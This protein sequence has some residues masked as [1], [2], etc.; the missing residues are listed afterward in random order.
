MKTPPRADAKARNSAAMGLP[1]RGLLWIGFAAALLIVAGVAWLASRPTTMPA[2]GAGAASTGTSHM[3]IEFVG[4]ASCAECHAT[5]HAA[6]TK[7]QHAR[8]MQHAS[9]DTVLGDFNGA[10]YTKD[11]VT[12]TFFRRDGKYYVRTDGPDG[13]LA[14]FEVKYTFGVEPLQQYLVE[15][16]G[17]RLQALAVSW[18]ARPERDGGQRWF[19]QYPD[20]KLDFRDELHWTRRSQNWNGMC[21]DCHSTDVRKGY[22]DAKDA[23]A[24]R[25]AEISVGCEAC[26]GP[27]SEH[28]AWAKS[29][30][31]A[32]ATK[33][34]TVLLDERR[35]AAWQIDPASG[36]AKRTPE[37]R[38]GREI[39]VCAPCHARRAQ[40][41]EGWRAGAPLMDHYLPS[42]LSAG[43]YY[44]DGQQRDEV[45]V[46]ASFLQSR[47][48]QAGV[49][50]SDCHDPHTQ[51]LRAPGNAVCAQCHLA[52]KYDS[53][54]H[55]FHAPQ[56]RAAEC[57]NC[58][59]PATT[60]MVVDPRRD[61]SIRVPRPDLSVTLGTPNACNGCHRENTAKWAAD[62]VARW[63]G[64]QR[65]NEAHYGEALDAGRLARPG[66]ARALVA[67]A[68]SV[69][70]P[71]I[72]R[73][74]AVELLAR[75]P[76]RSGDDAVRRALNDADPLVRHA[77][78]VALQA[79]P[80]QAL[81]ALAPLFGDPVRAV[82]IEA[83][84]R[85]VPLAARLDPAARGAFDKA[86]SEFE[87][88]Q[89]RSLDSPEAW[90]N[91]GNLSMERGDLAGAEAAYRAALRRE[92]RFVPA[93]A[94]LADLRR[95]Q[96][97]DA[98]A[99]AILRDGLQAAPDAAALHE[100]L[101]FTLVR[102]GKK[103]AALA[104]F[105][106]ARKAA[107][108]EARYAYL[109]ALALHDAGR[110]PEAIRVLAES[111]KRGGDRDV[112]LA[113]AMYRSEGGDEA[114]AGEALKALA[115]VNPDDPALAQL[116]AG[117]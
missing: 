100:A 34:L 11:G 44:P 113:L 76:G 84:R 71:A 57:A 99:E 88:V 107:P 36:N 25:W 3:P 7:S 47:M 17:G 49:T 39:E 14:D 92:P 97:R 106:A 112:L 18:D 48:H 27:G 66:A 40:I 50:C 2:A 115:A 35:G 22:D 102:Q 94:N 110:R 53:K 54:A 28:L 101:G 64:P 75:Y 68:T 1:L 59:M 8:A 45:F 86:I 90:M 67:I 89:R 58:H 21:A 30:P 20:E 63:Y 60:Y 23:F 31:A 55:H 83:A 61:H 43:L 26:H 105:A 38:T 117:R 12:S 13:K 73:A 19:R 98:D 80:A 96:R 109:H 5:Q 87:A 46:W 95:A 93:Y 33:G 37:R 103:S 108:G 114:G 10:K 56:S 79:P 104:E 32:D 77:A 70:Y 6:W 42:V 51:K 91:L 111:A 62:A 65:R 29:R 41:A 16:P 74:S 69:A 116:R 85:A 78:V 4:S 72:V 52:S 24:T 15:L 9:A 81:N 82:R